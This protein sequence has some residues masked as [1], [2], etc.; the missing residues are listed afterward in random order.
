MKTRIVN[1]KDLDINCWSARRYTDSCE[2]CNNVKICE[3]EEGKR[4]RLRKKLKKAIEETE[5]LQFIF[6]EELKLDAT[7]LDET[8][9]KIKSK[10][11]ILN[12]SRHPDIKNHG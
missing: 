2:D 12:Q 9:A 1:S 6:D 3:L 8:I 11:D 10:L 5:K 7:N 4:G